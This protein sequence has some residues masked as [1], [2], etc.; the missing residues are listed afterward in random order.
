SL[1]GY[2][3]EMA[4]QGVKPGQI[5]FYNTDYNAQAGDLVSSKVVKIGGEKAG[6]LY[7]NTAIISSGPTGN[8]RLPNFQPAAIGE[9]CRREYQARAAAKS[10]AA[11]RAT[12]AAYGATTGTCAFIRIIARAL[13]NAGTNPT[14]AE[15]ASAVE[16][17]GALDGGDILPSFEPGKYTA[18]NALY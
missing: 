10:R 6:A 8:F 13:D 7:N 1:P 14:R 3:S 18:P 12:N 5:Q 9:S 17:L 2:L 15:L 16:H 11:A 4:T